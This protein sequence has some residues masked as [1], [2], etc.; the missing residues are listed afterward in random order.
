M[1]QPPTPHTFPTVDTLLHKTTQTQ[2]PLLPPTPQEPVEHNAVIEQALKNM[3]HLITL[4]PS[5]EG[6][7]QKEYFKICSDYFEVVKGRQFQ[8]LPDEKDNIPLELCKQLKETLNAKHYFL[9]IIKDFLT[10][11]NP[12]DEQAKTLEALT[13]FVEVYK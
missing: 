9:Q 1:T 10:A 6:L 3:A 4:G 2:N 12:T 13:A 5:Q 7:T 8:Y 11:Y